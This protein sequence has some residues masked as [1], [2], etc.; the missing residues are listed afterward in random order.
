MMSASWDTDVFCD[1]DTSNPCD[2]WLGTATDLHLSVSVPSRLTLHVRVLVIANRASPPG[3]HVASH[4]AVES[5]RE[6][7]ADARTARESALK[8]SSVAVAHSL[9]A[10]EGRRMRYEL[11]DRRP[12]HA[13]RDLVELTLAVDPQ[14]PHRPEVRPS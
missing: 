14:P 9:C 10:P 7:T 6:A 8:S 11:V 5:R 2:Q 13:L 1:D 4:S 3:S 12:G